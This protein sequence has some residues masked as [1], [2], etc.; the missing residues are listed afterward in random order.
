[1]F[2]KLLQDKAL[3]TG[4][5]PGGS[6]FSKR[7]LTKSP[8]STLAS[9]ASTG[10]SR[11]KKQVDPTS[12]RL[13][14]SRLFLVHLPNLFP[15]LQPFLICSVLHPCSALKYY[16]HGYRTCAGQF[17]NAGYP[18][19]TAPTEFSDINAG[20]ANAP[21]PDE[22]VSPEFPESLLRAHPEGEAPMDL[23]DL[24]E[25]AVPLRVVPPP[26]S[27]KVTPSADA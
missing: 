8:P 4:K 24:A 26:A 2:N 7:M 10:D 12:P 11:G 16:Y 23:E 1:M 14:G 3:D 17:V 5:G 15:N 18:P 21:E 22:E 19:L 27:D 13:R 9:S 25:D 6:S 20:L